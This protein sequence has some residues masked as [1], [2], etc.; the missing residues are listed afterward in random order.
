VNIDGR[1]H[2]QDNLP[3]GK[4][5]DKWFYDPRVDRTTQLGDDDKLYGRPFDRGHLVRR[6]DPAWGRTLRVAKVAKDDTFHWTNCSPQHETFNQRVKLWAGLENFLLDK[7]TDERKRLTVFTGPVLSRAD[8]EWDERPGVQ[9]PS[10]FWKVAIVARP[11]G[12][13]ATL[14]FI[15]S[16][17][18]FLAE[19]FDPRAVAEEYQVSVA[20]VERLTGLDFGPLRE[21]DAR[22]VATFPAGTEERLLTD[23]SQIVIPL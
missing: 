20:K 18:Q 16:Q 9:I 14:G 19:V 17:E 7:A 12:R 21:L 5:R 11:N 15:A 4:A 2:K 22:S 10:R 1:L 23:A 6:L 3:R 8:R 13:V